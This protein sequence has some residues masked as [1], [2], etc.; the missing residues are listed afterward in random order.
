MDLEALDLPGKDR[1]AMTGEALPESV[2]VS[3]K[4]LHDLFCRLTH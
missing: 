1:Q 4:I 2:T 3:D